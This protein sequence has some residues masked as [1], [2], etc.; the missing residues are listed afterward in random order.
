MR[1]Q[2]TDL[3]SPLKIQPKSR[4]KHQ[5]YPSIIGFYFKLELVFC[6]LIG[7]IVSQQR[8]FECF[9]CFVYKEF[10]TFCLVFSGTQ[11]VK[12][13]KPAKVLILHIS[14]VVHVAQLGTPPP[15]S[16]PKVLNFL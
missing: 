5:F 9:C 13:F 3:C 4:V 11:T 10:G 14:S 15:S 16:M 2:P 7:A 12:I 6:S 1:R 8:V